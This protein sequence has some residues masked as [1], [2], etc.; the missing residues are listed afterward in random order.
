VRNKASTPVRMP[1]VELSLS[2]AQGLT[3][4]RRVLGADELG[5]STQSLPASAEVMLQ[6][7]LDLGDRR[8]AGYT[9]EL[10]YP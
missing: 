1:D 7:T 9:V 6:A 10:F 5:R 2:D 8:V 4:V 3:V